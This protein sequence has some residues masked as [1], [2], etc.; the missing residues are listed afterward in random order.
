MAN[1]SAECLGKQHGK[2]L[3]V[4]MTEATMPLNNNGDNVVLSDSEGVGRS[5]VSYSGAQVKV[6]AI[7]KFAAEIE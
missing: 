4:V 1:S 2:T 3:T 7:V 5:Q 6:G